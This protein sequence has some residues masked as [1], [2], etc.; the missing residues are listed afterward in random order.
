MSKGSVEEMIK[1]MDD[2]VSLLSST[3]SRTRIVRWEDDLYSQ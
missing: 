2:E 1:E 3:R